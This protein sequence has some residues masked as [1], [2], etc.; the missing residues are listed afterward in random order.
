MEFEPGSKW[1]YS[2]YGLV[3]LGGVIEKVPGM[4]YYDFLSE[5][6]FE[7]GEC[8]AQV[9]CRKRRRRARDTASGHGGGAPGM[10]GELRVYPKTGTVV[11]VLANLD[12]PAATRVADIFDEKMPLD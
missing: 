4:S 7:K 6:I 12:P 9:L 11:V 2:N 10:N 3:L 5:N 8:T 1:A